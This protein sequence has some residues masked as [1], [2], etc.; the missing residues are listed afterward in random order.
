MMSTTTA[1]FSIRLPQ[2]TKDKIDS[3]ARAMGRPRNYLI[4]E[5]IERYIQEESW[6][7][8]EIQAGIAEDD[9]GLAV[10]HE[11]VMRD[12]YE[13]IRQAEEGRPS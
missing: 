1:N 7:I 4:A 9:A 10:P 12:A 13:V 8:A 6:Q 3:L 5:A 11:E 2:E